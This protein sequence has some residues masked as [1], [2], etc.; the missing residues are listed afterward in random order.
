MASSEICIDRRVGSSMVDL[1]LYI[2]GN[3]STKVTGDGLLVSTPGG[4]TGYQL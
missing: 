2:N 4:S 3:Y 1:D